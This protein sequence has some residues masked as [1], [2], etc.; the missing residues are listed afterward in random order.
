MDLTI[1][2]H[3]NAIDWQWSPMVKHGMS[4]ILN[5]LVVSWGYRKTE[6]VKAGKYHT[7]AHNRQNYGGP[8]SLLWFADKWHASAR[9]LRSW[10]WSLWLKLRGIRNNKHLGIPTALGYNDWP[11]ALSSLQASI[12]MFKALFDTVVISTTCKRW[13]GAWPAIPEPE[14]LSEPLPAAAA[15]LRPWVPMARALL[16]ITP[17]RGRSICFHD[18][19][20]SEAIMSV[21]QF[22]IISTG[23]VHLLRVISSQ[24]HGLWHCLNFN[25]LSIFWWPIWEQ[26]TVHLNYTLTSRICQQQSWLK[27]TCPL[28]I[29]LDGLGISKPPSIAFECIPHGTWQASNAFSPP[30]DPSQVPFCF[31]F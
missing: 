20:L 28:I 3:T 21:E 9:S 23:W 29:S 18:M 12:Q 16:A 2:S 15:V 17:G 22:V 4:R 19:M 5:G 1:R 8:V 26:R 13:G 14:A 25:V 6:V 30:P 31:S 24:N 10:S 11:P 27:L 7:R